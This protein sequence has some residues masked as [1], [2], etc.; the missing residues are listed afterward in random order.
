MALQHTAPVHI[1][2]N[3]NVLSHAVNVMPVVYCT[4]PKRVDSHCNTPSCGPPKAAPLIKCDFHFMAPSLLL[5]QSVMDRC[6]QLLSRHLSGSCTHL[7]MWFHNLATRPE[8][9]I[10]HP[11]NYIHQCCAQHKVSVVLWCKNIRIMGFCLFSVAGLM[12][13]LNWKTQLCW[14]YVVPPRK[15]LPNLHSF[16]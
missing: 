5:N 7:E 6:I 13:G 15:C 14:M 2:T 10:F 8:P 12:V 16:H 4:N 11:M 3:V 9:Q 1:A